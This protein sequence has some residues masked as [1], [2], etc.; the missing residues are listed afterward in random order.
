MFLETS[1]G[2]H[3]GFILA[4]GLPDLLRSLEAVRGNQRSKFK[5]VKNINSLHL[6]ATHCII[7]HIPQ[8]HSS[9]LLGVEQANL[10]YYCQLEL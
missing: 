5:I 6:I 1:R 2:K 3:V 8:S 7:I 10:H 4:L 9:K